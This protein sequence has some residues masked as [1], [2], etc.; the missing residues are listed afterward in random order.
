[1]GQMNQQAVGTQIK[2]LITNEFFAI[3]CTQSNGQPYGSIISGAFSD[4]LKY[5]VFATPKNTR[6][7]NF[8]QNNNQVAIVIDDRSKYKDDLGKLSAVTITGVATHLKK[9]EDIDKWVSLLTSRHPTLS[10]FILSPSS[11]IILVECTEFTYVTSFQQVYH[12]SPV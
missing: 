1:M 8:L 10:E 2:S 11:A 7:F 6:K 3:L 5:L 4:D 12:W 9:E